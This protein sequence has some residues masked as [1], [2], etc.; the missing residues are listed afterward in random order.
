MK[1]L[2]QYILPIIFISGCTTAGDPIHYLRHQDIPPPTTESFTHC[3]DYGCKNTVTVVLS[4]EIKMSMERLLKE[5]P[6]S[7]AE[8]REKIAQA[9]AGFEKTIGAVTGTE[10]D[11]YGTFRILQESDN[12][13]YDPRF[14]QDCVDES[15]N[16]TIYLLLLDQMGLL[17]YHAP[18]FPAS[19]S[20]SMHSF[21]WHKTAV[22]TEIET[23]EKF[24]VDSWFHDNGN[25]AEIIALEE[26]EKGW[27]PAKTNIKSDS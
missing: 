10:A 25:N 4:D 21:W 26:W 6:L 1:R 9:I 17:H 27:K 14:Q 7:A 16:T 3:Y 2:A 24:A 8:E 22:M 23:G 20:P 18:A 11:K 12:K 13:K 5:K 15:T 19:R